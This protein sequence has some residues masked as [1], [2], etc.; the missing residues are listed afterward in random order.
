MSPEQIRGEQVDARSDI[1]S[2]GATLFEMLS[3]RPPFWEGNIEYHHLHT[4]PPP[5]PAETD[6]MLAAAVLRG[7]AKD[8][9]DRY[10]TIED[11]SEAV[12]RT[13]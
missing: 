8:K 4:P 7:L 10:Q 1:Y 13:E 2:L 9:D 5:L 3:G 11:L 6:T 12:A